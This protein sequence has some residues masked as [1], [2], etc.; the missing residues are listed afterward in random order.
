GHTAAVTGALFTPDGKGVVSISHDRTVRL[1][2]VAAGKEAKKL[3]DTKDDPYGLAFSPDGKRLA[4]S[5]YAG[6]LVLWDVAGGKQVAEV[7]LETFGAYC[8]AFSRDGK[9]LVT[10]HDN[11]HCHLTP[12]PQG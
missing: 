2:D 6:W 11:Q 9:T 8:V 12:V 4:T 10:G 5:G 3:G 7:K 1:W